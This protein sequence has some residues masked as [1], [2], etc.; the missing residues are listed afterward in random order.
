MTSGAATAMQAGEWW[1][2]LLSGN[3]PEA[4]REL[5]R[6][7]DPDLRLTAAQIVLLQM[8]STDDRLAKMWAQDDVG[9]EPAWRQMVE[10]QFVT[11]QVLL[12]P[13]LRS[14]SW[15][16]VDGEDVALGP[17]LEL[18]IACP[19]HDPGVSQNIP[20]HAT[21]EAFSAVAR[22]RDDGWRVAG[23]G[24][25]LA[26]P[27]TGLESSSTWPSSVDVGHMRDTRGAD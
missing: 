5:W 25:Q 27:G 20:P 17:D 6:V 4:A 16:M 11:W 21:R 3:G 23:I 7:T 24:S 13:W 19:L 15:G 18:A 8:G 2:G 9:P 10:A 1:F 12:P 22:L 26:V 14:P